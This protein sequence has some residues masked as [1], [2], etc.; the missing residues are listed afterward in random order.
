MRAEIRKKLQFL[1]EL[2]L[3]KNEI[4]ELLDS[5]FLIEQSVDLKMRKK[6]EEEVVDEEG[7]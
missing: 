5:Q 7:Y 2:G 1:Q 6:R 3:N 4:N